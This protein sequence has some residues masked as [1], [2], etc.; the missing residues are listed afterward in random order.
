[1]RKSILLT[2]A[3]VNALSATLLSAQDTHTI[4]PLLSSVSTIPGNGDVN[5]YGVAFAPKNIPTNG[6]LKPGDILVSNFNDAQNLQGRG[7]TILRVSTDGKTST[8][9]QSSS[10]QTGLTA[11]LGVLSDG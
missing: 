7:S 6:V 3:L 11:A 1:M 2:I 5:P 9:F 10:P 4:L 8:F